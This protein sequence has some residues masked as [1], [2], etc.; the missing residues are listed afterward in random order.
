[1]RLL[2]DTSVPFRSPSGAVVAHVILVPV[3]EAESVSAA[4]LT[5]TDGMS[6]RW[7][8]PPTTRTCGCGAAFQAVAVVLALVEENRM[9]V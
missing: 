4:P 7:C 9:R 6:M 3:K 5:D 2:A 8:R 1:M